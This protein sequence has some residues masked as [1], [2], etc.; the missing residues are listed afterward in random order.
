MS[1]LLVV[2]QDVEPVDPLE[3]RVGR[4]HRPA[5]VPNHAGDER[6]E[7]AD[8]LAGVVELAVDAGR[9]RRTA[10]G[11]I[12]GLDPVEVRPGPFES[13]LA[14]GRTAP[15]NVSNSATDGEKSGSRS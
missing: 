1:V 9:L 2:A 5:S 13:V 4:D 10:D 11:E 3:V 15:T 14:A 8:R 6:I 12:D 7:R